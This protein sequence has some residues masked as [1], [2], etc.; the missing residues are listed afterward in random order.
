ML[1]RMKPAA[2][3]AWGSTA[4][5]LLALAVWAWAGKLHTLRGDIPDQET[6]AH[7]LAR[8]RDGAPGEMLKHCTNDVVGFNRLV[9]SRLD[10]AGDNVKTWSGEVTVEYVN[11]VGGIDRTNLHYR[12]M[13][14]YDGN[15]LTLAAA[16][17]GSP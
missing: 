4:A 5:L 2:K 12:F 14:G 3:I 10:T 8:W 16:A 15:L 13:A 7:R 11:H 17:P 1:P 9:D 6:F